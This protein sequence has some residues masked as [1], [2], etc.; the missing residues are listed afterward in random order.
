M[1]HDVVIFLGRD[2]YIGFAL[3][4]GNAVVWNILWHIF[5]ITM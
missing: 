2:L 5:G 1:L 3:L 4:V